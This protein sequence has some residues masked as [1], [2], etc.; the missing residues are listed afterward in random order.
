MI[1]WNDLPDIR[2]RLCYAKQ[3]LVLSRRCQALCVARGEDADGSVANVKKFKAMIRKFE[4]RL[5]DAEKT[6]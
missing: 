1:D 2:R 5:S 4:A 6:K 3:F